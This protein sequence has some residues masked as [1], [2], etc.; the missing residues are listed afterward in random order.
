LQPA[1]SGLP[2]GEVKRALTALL[3]TS[4][5]DLATA[6]EK[7]E[8]WFNDAMDRVSGWYKRRTQIWTIATALVLTLAVNAD[9]LHI[10]QRLWTDPALRAQVVEEARVRASKPRPSTLVEYIDR[11][12]LK[13]TVKPVEGDRIADQ[14][15]A[16][17][18]QMVGWSQATLRG[19]GA[20]DW[21]ARLIGWILTIIAISLGAPFWFDLLNRFMNVR[22]A[23][24][25]PDEAAKKPEKKKLPPEDKAA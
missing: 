13:P 4:D 24:R 11:D 6:Q 19:N 22:S 1:V 5:R 7:I 18:G 23:G 20:L 9:T 25:S 14:E 3:R 8:G 16:T 17:L 15:R 21:L 2:D 12:P 10:A